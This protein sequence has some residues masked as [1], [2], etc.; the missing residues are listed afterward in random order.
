MKRWR[1]KQLWMYPFTRS[2]LGEDLYEWLTAVVLGTQRGMSRKWCYWFREHLVL[3]RRF[4]RIRIPGLRVWLY[5]PGWSL[6]PVVMS[7]IVTGI[8]PFVTEDRRRL[9]RRYVALAVGEVAKVASRIGAAAGQPRP[10]LALLDSLRSARS[11]NQ[12][13]EVCE[14]RYHVGDLTDLEAFPPESAD[15][16]ISMGRLEHYAESDLAYLFSQMRRVLAPGGVGSHIVDHRD[17]Y[18]HFDK[19]LHCFHHLTYSDEE[20][21]ALARGRKLFRNRLLE[22]DYVRLFERTGFDV[23]ARVH[24]LHREDASTLDP[25]TLW[26]RYKALSKADLEAAVSHFVVR[27]A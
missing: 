4:A 18:W 24:Q 22:A 5:Q 23:L 25:G 14:A 17:H 1:I 9:A 13:L 11:P 20:W 27:R 26:G 12:V 8:G 19:S 10:N 7:R 21:A 6:A 3:C 16:C 15:L 2:R